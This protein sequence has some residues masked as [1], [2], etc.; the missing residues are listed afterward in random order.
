MNHFISDNFFLLNPK[1]KNLE[2]FKER[3]LSTDIDIE[4]LKFNIDKLSNNISENDHIMIK[5][6]ILGQRDVFG[7]NYLRSRII[8]TYNYK[9]KSYLLYTENRGPNPTDSLE[10]EL[11]Y[12]MIRIFDQD[13]DFANDIYYLN[14]I[15]VYF[16]PFRYSLNSKTFILFPRDQWSPWNTVLFDIYRDIIINAIIVTDYKVQTLFSF[17]KLEDQ[18]ENLEKIIKSKIKLIE[19]LKKKCKT[20]ITNS[21]PRKSKKTRTFKPILNTIPNTKTRNSKSRRSLSQ[22]HND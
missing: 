6:S 9:I 10:L 17:G 11:K 5:K 15:L 7:K 22:S 14:N 16:D 13:D 8:L 3:L 4:E 20:S 19:E 1:D 12:A 18:N 21:L 2:E